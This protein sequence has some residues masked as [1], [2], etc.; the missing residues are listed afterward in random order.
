M[1]ADHPRLTLAERRMS[2]LVMNAKGGAG[3]TTLATNLAAAYA[4]HGGD[5]LVDHDPRP[6]R[7]SGSPPDRKGVRRFWASRPIAPAPAALAL[8]CETRTTLT[9][10]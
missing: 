2:V 8:S 7:P 6:A 4:H 3:K 10:S 1:R 9:A 5:A